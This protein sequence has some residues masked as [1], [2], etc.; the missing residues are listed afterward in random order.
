MRILVMKVGLRVS[1]VN[2]LKEKRMV[3]RSL[4]QRMKNKFN[5]SVSEVDDQDIH[6]SI[7]IGI[8]A[9]STSQDILYSTYES[10]VD[11]IEDNTDGEIVYIEKDM[12]VFN[13]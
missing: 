6:K 13:I 12:E 5:I 7:V 4:M 11:F 3:I 9:V 10:L 1:W 2:S 8:V